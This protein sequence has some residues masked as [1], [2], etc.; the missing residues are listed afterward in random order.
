[1]SIRAGNKRI[2]VLL[3]PTASG[4]SELAITIAKWLR[5]HGV[6]AEVISA[7]SR[8][9]YRKLCIGTCKVSGKWQSRGKSQIAKGKSFVYKGVPHHLID[10]VSPRRTYSPAEYAEAGRKIIHKLFALGH[11][12]IVCG[13]TGQY[14]DALLGAHPIPNVP[15]DAKLRTRLAK[16]SAP[17]LFAR[18]K[19]LDPR[20][21]KTIDRHNPR[22][23]VRALEIVLKTGHPV[24]PLHLTKHTQILENLRMFQGGG[25]I[26][27]LKI[28][29]NP[30]PE[31]SRRRINARLVKDLKRG[32][33]SEARKLH[34]QG[35]SWKR[36]NEL[37][38]EYRLVGQ[39]LRG[40]IQTKEDLLQKLQREL[41]QYAKRQ[42]RWWKRD[43]SIVWTRNE[44]DALK[45]ARASL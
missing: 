25:G 34:E 38:L 19:K 17:K 29:L 26:E 33:V 37:G 5:R 23:L 41:W 31:E 10:F 7:D 12:P 18:L 32:L 24:P 36:L 44:R 13:G 16:L 22:R 20:R 9:V 2:L 15:P 28:G 14:I 39:F 35:L 6:L 30:P 45:I 8:Q 3:G 42:L 4:K 1:M 43:T 11:L 21:A 27:V 40:E